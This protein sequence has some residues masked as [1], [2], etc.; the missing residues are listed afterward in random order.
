M[1]AINFYDF[2]LIQA[3]PLCSGA[4][5]TAQKLAELPAVNKIRINAWLK[6]AMAD[7]KIQNYQ[8]RCAMRGGKRESL[9]L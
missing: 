5:K 7:R 2:F 6:L 9:L 3:E 8:S 1:A 4:A